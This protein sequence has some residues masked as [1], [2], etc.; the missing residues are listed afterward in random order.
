MKEN[1]LLAGRITLN[2]MMSS[3]SASVE[4]TCLDGESV[5]D[6]QCRVASILAA[7]Q[8][9]I[10][11]AD[12]KTAQ[13]TIEINQR[14]KAHEEAT[15]Q[16]HVE[17]LS[18]VMK[19]PKSDANDASISALGIEISQREKA[20]EF[21]ENIIKSNQDKI[22]LLTESLEKLQDK[23]QRHLVGGSD[24]KPSDS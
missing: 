17:N 18:I 4:V 12:I 23:M 14:Q 13:S 7:L 3:G 10:I 19:K 6:Y 9:Q 21:L 2:V 1:Q 15:L 22:A 24:A 11:E 20:L 8:P 5:L 16:M